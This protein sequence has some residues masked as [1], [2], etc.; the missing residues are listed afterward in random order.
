MLLCSY[1]TCVLTVAIGAVTVY[2]KGDM[3]PHVW[4]EQEALKQLKEEGAI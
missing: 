1:T 4:G 2:A 3:N